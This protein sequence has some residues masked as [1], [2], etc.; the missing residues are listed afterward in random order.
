MPSG[1]DV[2]GPSRECDAFSLVK[3]RLAISSVLRCLIALDLFLM[4]MTRVCAP[5]LGLFGRVNAQVSTKPSRNTPLSGRS[6][7]S[8][9]TSTTRLRSLPHPLLSGALIRVALL[10]LP[11]LQIES[12]MSGLC[13][14]CTHALAIGGSATLQFQSSRCLPSSVSLK[15]NGAR[16]AGSK[17]QQCSVGLQ[18]QLVLS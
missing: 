15:R 16:R 5:L 3:L 10:Q 4:I 1:L 18:R 13:Q 12:G 8:T 11:P 17:I 14:A 2:Q 6:G 9:R 7:V